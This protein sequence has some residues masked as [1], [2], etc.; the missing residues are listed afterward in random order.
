MSR[1]AEHTHDRIGLRA[2]CAKPHPL[3]EIRMSRGYSIDDLAIT[4][5]LT[6]QE[7]SDIENGRSRD[8]RHFRRIATALQIP[9]MAL[10][11]PRLPL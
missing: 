1:F 11:A 7:I 8:I 9:L 3:T 5:G 10:D 6:W 4:S 2:D